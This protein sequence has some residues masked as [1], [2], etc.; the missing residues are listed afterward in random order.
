LCLWG[1][2]IDLP[3]GRVPKSFVASQQIAEFAVHTWDLATATGQRADFP[4]EACDA[5]LAWARSALLPQFRGERHGVRAR[6]TG[7]RRRAR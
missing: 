1:R 3:I 4:A 2:I 7:T 6:G 5:A